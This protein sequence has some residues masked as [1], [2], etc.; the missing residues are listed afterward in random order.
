MNPLYKIHSLNKL[1]TPFK[2][3]YKS[4][5]LKKSEMDMNCCEKRAQ[6]ECWGNT[7][8]S[9]KREAFG[10]CA[11]KRMTWP[12]KTTVRRSVCDHALFS[13]LKTQRVFVDK[14]EGAKILLV[15]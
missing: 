3:S 6:K 1:K 5:T 13:S 9:K 4:I 7:I 12:Y 11:R 2:N 15:I 8:G 14:N 10:G